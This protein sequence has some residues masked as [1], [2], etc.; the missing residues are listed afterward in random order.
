MGA[1][2]FSAVD[3][4]RAFIKFLAGEN[5][6]GTEIGDHLISQVSN[7]KS[8]GKIWFHNYSYTEIMEELRANGFEVLRVNDVAEIE[9]GCTF[10]EIIRRGAVF[11]VI[12]ARKV[13]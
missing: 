2:I 4:Y 10:P 3:L 13:S 5:Y 12:V 1:F 7:A 6:K 9:S 8:R 11:I